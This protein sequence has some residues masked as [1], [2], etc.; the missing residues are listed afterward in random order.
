M[1]AGSVDART[2]RTRLAFGA[3]RARHGVHDLDLFAVIATDTASI[4]AGY[5]NGADFRS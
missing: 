2:W 1:V 3:A 5:D 4:D